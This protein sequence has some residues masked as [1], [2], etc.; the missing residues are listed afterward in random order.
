MHGWKSFLGSAAK[1]LAGTALGYVVSILPNIP[2]DTTTKTGAGIS[3]A[4]FFLADALKNI[5]M[6]HKAERQ[7][8][9]TED[10]TAA[11]KDGI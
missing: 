7:I 10:N 9:A 4:I 3:V 2:L 6:A 1:G 5:G 8:Q 11:V